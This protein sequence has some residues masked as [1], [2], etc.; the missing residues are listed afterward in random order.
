M[1]GIVGLV[2]V[3]KAL[4]QIILKYPCT[5]LSILS[6]CLCSG[7]LVFVF[8]G[9]FRLFVFIEDGMRI[10]SLFLHLIDTY[11]DFKHWQEIKM[12]KI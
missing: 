5:L 9:V 4:T 7:V 3:N 8:S 1:E 10:T 6:S 2:G 11:E 12:E